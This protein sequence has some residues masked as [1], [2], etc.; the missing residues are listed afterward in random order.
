MPA[1]SSANLATVMQAAMSFS[2]KGTAS[3]EA[4]KQLSPECQANGMKERRF[5]RITRASFDNTFATEIYLVRRGVCAGYRPVPRN[6]ERRQGVDQAGPTE[7]F[8]QSGWEISPYAAQ[9]RSST[10]EAAALCAV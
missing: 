6:V 4:A 3:H 10:S 1:G 5:G 9:C 7:G 2:R 8:A